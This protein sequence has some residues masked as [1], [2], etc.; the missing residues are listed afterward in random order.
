MT[1]LLARRTR[2]TLSGS[3]LFFALLS[4]CSTDIGE[5]PPLGEGGESSQ[6][7]SGGS[8]AARAG[9][10]G[11]ASAG[12]SGKSGGGAGSGG[13]EGGE[14]GSATG[15][16]SAGGS[17]AGGSS[18]GGSS[19]GGAGS[20]GGSSGSAPS[21]GRAGAEPGAGPTIGGCA[22]FPAAD[23]W[24]RDISAVPVDADWTAR[25][26][27][28][29]GDVNIHPDYGSG[30]G[31]L[32]GIPIN[33]VPENQPGV[34]VNFYWYE[35]ESDPAPY[36]FPDPGAVAIEGNDPNECDGDCH[37]LVVQQGSCQLFEGYACYHEDGWQCGGG[38]RWDLTEVSYGQREKGW[39]S[40]DAAGLAITPGI[41]RYDEVRA[42][43]VSHAL[44]FTVPCTRPNFVEPAT[45]YAVP[46]GCDENDPNA[47]PMGLRVRL[48]A[49]YDMSGA[50]ASA[51][52]VLR[53]MQ[54]Y[55]MILADN[56][57][58]FYFQGEANPGWTEDDI[59]P[60]KDVPASAFEVI[61]LPPLEE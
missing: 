35:D 4:A 36:P 45:H 60:L 26:A 1:A 11:S 21:A 58:S 40:A 55:G 3:W 23:A 48:R 28:L 2:W 12:G 5:D 20:T 14:A 38:A 41:L 49:D 34:P 44:R 9:S 54:R 10:S 30:D 39:T 46:G 8:G 37:V 7:G 15:G 56:G 16:S 47:P 43:E 18:A 42:G 13:S 51:Q 6:A 24:N 59:E 33:V 19:A 32:Y 53:A 52:V 29:V 57:S 31:E 27:N 50:S 22:V 17:S 25:L 61:E